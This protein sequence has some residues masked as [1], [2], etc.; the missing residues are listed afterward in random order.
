VAV[1]V[2]NEERVRRPF[3][4]LAWL[5][6]ASG[7]LLLAFSAG[8]FPLVLTSRLLLL[9][10]VTVVA[11]NYAV[12]MPGWGVSLTYP[13]L[14]AIAVMCGPTATLLAAV[15]IA[16]NLQEIRMRLS[17]T[18]HAFNFGQ[19]LI[20]FGLASWSY[21][22][23]GGR[24]LTSTD[25]VVTP[26]Q[27]A[28]FPEIL[29]PLV[30]MFAIGAL[31]N[32]ALL[33]VGYA[34]K[35]GVR[36]RDV[37]SQLGWLPAAQFA[38]ATVG[39]MLAQIMAVNVLA[40]PLFV[41]PLFIARQFYQRFMALQDAYTETVRSLVSGLEAKDSYTRGHSERVATYALALGKQCGLDDR[42][43]ADI[44]TAALLHDLGKLTIG[45]DILRKEGRLTDEE[46]VLIRLHPEIG[47][48]MVA[49]IPHLR[50]L[51]STVASHHER[52]DGSGY[53]LGLSSDDVP[54][55]ARILAI[56]DSYDAMTTD[57][58][59]RPGLSPEA[60]LSEL[61]A[62]S[63]SMYDSGLVQQFCEATHPERQ[64]TREPG[65]VPGT[66]YAPEGDAT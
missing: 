30:A 48:A 24:V 2:S 62:C 35:Q 61:R 65:V 43:L 58:P 42:A 40:L 60:A 1:A 8:A 29:L 57:R 52:L 7:V 59:Y 3:S 28:E 53:P 26:I 23:L 15:L 64:I 38:L 5:L 12:A 36:L 13:L 66:V 45:G 39:V 50:R 47:A 49:R 17:L 63:P 10:A 6:F 34:S 18:V 27:P 25:G 21:V 9:V 20:S 4:L 32:F 56:A 37:V 41:F 19:L 54:L 44:E 51:A 33:V 55:A 14:I 16:V 46:W 31:G 22:L 11:E